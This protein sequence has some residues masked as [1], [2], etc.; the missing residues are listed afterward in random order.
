MNYLCPYTHRAPK[1]FSRCQSLTRRRLMCRPAVGLMAV[2][3]YLKSSFL[4]SPHFPVGVWG[5]KIKKKKCE[6]VPLDRKVQFRRC[7]KVQRQENDEKVFRPGW[8]RRANVNT[9]VGLRGWRCDVNADNSDSMCQNPL[10]LQPHLF[11]VFVS[12]MIQP[13]G[14]FICRINVR[15][16]ISNAAVVVFAHKKIDGYFKHPNIPTPEMKGAPG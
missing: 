13:R 1:H 8:R 2:S 16:Q 4:H 15:S 3:C 11:S 6:C 10:N 9:R 7:S 12:I 5:Q 14:S